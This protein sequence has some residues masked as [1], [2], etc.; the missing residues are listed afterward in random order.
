MEQNLVIACIKESTYRKN[1]HR[2]VEVQRIPLS[3]LQMGAELKLSEQHK[4]SVVKLTEEEL[5]FVIDD[6]RCY[7][8]NRYWQVLGTVKL[9][10]YPCY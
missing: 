7:T 10:S 6:L 1:Q 8:L 9:N 2:N 5:T 4:M 3:K